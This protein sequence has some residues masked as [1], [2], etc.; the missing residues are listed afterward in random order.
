MLVKVTYTGAASPGKEVL[1][2]GVMVHSDARHALEEVFNLL[3]RRDNVSIIEGMDAIAIG[4]GVPG[5]RSMSVGDIIEVKGLIKVFND[6][7]PQFRYTYGEPKRYFT[8]SVGFVEIK[9]DATLEAI[10]KADHRDLSMG[11]KWLFDKKIVSYS[12]VEI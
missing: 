12:S 5:I 10:L 3:Q 7:S 8:D 9:D 11:W 4:L 6:F 2:F 1:S